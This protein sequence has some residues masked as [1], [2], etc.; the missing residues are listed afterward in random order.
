MPSAR[1]R[2][3]LSSRVPGKRGACLRAS[4]VRQFAWPSPLASALLTFRL[5][6]EIASP[7]FQQR[8]R[9]KHK[10]ELKVVPKNWFNGIRVSTHLFNSEK[11]VDALVAV[12]K[13][14]LA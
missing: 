8:M 6:D 4:P 3:P 13:T 2:L 11:D 5:P 9:E 10:I 12:L 7:V 14:E 1:L